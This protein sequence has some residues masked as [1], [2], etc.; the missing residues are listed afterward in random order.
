M[1]ILN[2]ISIVLKGCLVLF[3]IPFLIKW[4]GNLKTAKLHQVF[5]KIYLDSMSKY[6][7]T[8]L[9]AFY[10]YRDSFDFHQ[11]QVYEWNNPPSL[12]PFSKN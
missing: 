10:L 8:N 2:K 11:S 7:R 3:M 4:Y 9:P 6:C 1:K 5:T 12:N